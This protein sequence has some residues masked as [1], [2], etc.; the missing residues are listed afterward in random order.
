MYRLQCFYYTLVAVGDCYPFNK[1]DDHS[2]GP[3][4]IKIK[5]IYYCQLKLFEQLNIN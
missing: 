5:R 4:Y 1:L 2:I 3:H